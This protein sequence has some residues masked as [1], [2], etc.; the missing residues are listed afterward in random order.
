MKT[1]KL[2][3]Y[4]DPGHGWVKVK[5]SEL[6]KYGIASKVSRCSYVRGDYVY[7]EEDCDAGLYID[8]LKQAGYNVTQNIKWTNKSSKIRN[9]MR[10][11]VMMFEAQQGA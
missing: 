7:L 9:Y 6:V 1:K 10:Y 11:S 5:F 3:V 8:A 4:T 2:T